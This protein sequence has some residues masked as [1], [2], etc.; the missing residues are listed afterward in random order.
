MSFSVDLGTHRVPT[1][2][3]RGEGVGKRLLFLHCCN[4]EQNE[5]HGLIS[6][7]SFMISRVEK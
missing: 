6:Q 1:A 7:I 3:L 4:W 5:T 2:G